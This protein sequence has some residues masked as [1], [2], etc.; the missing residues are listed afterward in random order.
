MTTG[1]VSVVVIT[2][3]RRAELLH[4]LDRICALPEAPEV[5]V[6]DNGSDDDT[7]AAVSRRHPAVRLLTLPTNAGAAAR[8]V[9]VAAARTPLVAF[10]DDDSWWAPGALCLAAA[11]FDAHPRLALLAA[12]VLVGPGQH[13]DP[14]CA[15]MAASPLPAAADLP[16]PSVLGFL[17][18]G[19][20][21]RRT[22][23]LDA[24]GFPAGFGGGGE[25]APLALAL[26]AE[27]W[28]LAYVEEVVAHHHPSPRRE[29]FARLAREHRN[30]IWTAWMR[31][32]LGDAARVSARELQRARH[33]RVA[34]AGTVDAVRHLGGV[35]RARRPVPR[36]L[37]D[38]WRALEGLGASSPPMF[39]AGDAGAPGGT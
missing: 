39:G 38:Q 13:L 34:R 29:S 35:L 12:K 22:P 19:A 33:D 23:F 17:A 20:V 30:R 5:I 8:N 26:A 4:A 36:A 1:G 7:V 32:P 24:G 10:S 11:H 14:T 16:G 18:C 31:L 6:V 25:E 9:G 28:G 27:G 37:A 21:V 15:A 2:R 3:D